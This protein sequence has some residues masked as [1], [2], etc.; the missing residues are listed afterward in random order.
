MG[1]RARDT[2][3]G[4]TGIVTGMAQYITGCD[5]VLLKP[6][7]DEKGAD[8]NGCWYDDGRLEYVDKGVKLKDVQGDKP[9]GPQS[10][11][12]TGK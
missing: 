11:A 12:P 6:K 5:Q 1:C 3:T 4:F 8:V 10:D 7:V 9:G 2:I